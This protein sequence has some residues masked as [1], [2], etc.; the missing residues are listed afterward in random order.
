MKQSNED[1]ARRV[2]FGFIVS[3]AIAAIF[4]L[5]MVAKNSGQTGGFGAGFGGVKT[6]TGQGGFTDGDEDPDDDD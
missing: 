1:N 4:A 5:G 3:C 6:T 2:F